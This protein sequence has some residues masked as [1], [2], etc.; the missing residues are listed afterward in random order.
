MAFFV[1]V[2]NVKEL[3][4][5][6]TK[7]VNNQI[8]RSLLLHDY[9]N[10]NGRHNFNYNYSKIRWILGKRLGDTTLFSFVGSVETRGENSDGESIER[11]ERRSFRIAGVHVASLVV[12]AAV[13]AVDAAVDA[14]VGPSPSEQVRTPVAD[15][16]V[17]PAL[18][19]VHVHA[20]GGVAAVPFAG[21][22]LRFAADQTLPASAREPRQPTE[23]R[24]EPEPQ[25]QAR[26]QVVLEERERE[27]RDRGPGEMARS[28]RWKTKRSADF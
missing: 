14:A 22:R 26:V 16:D 19:A 4:L 23:R 2:E 1:Q 17:F 27:R 12:R 25:H 13:A 28:A 5:Y 7:Q 15:P 21:P 6:D 8:P 3:H 18:F 20:P 9:N 11:D 10:Y 24:G